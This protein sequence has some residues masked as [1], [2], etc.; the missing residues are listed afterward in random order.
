MSFG[1]FMFAWLSRNAR[2]GIAVRFLVLGAVVSFGYF[3]QFLL[4]EL[5]SMRIFTIFPPVR[6]TGWTVSIFAFLVFA[7]ILDLVGKFQIPELGNIPRTS[8]GCLRVKPLRLTHVVLGILTVLAF[9]WTISSHRAQFVWSSEFSEA[10]L[11]IQ[12]ES[13]DDEIFAISS[14]LPRHTFAVET[15]RPLFFGAGFPFIEAEMFEWEMPMKLSDGS[16]P[17]QP[18][19]ADGYFTYEPEGGLPTLQSSNLARFM[20]EENVAYFIDAW[21]SERLDTCSPSFADK[22]LRLFSRRDILNCS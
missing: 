22:S 15:N 13:A 5:L 8:T 17:K 21:D 10:T 7:L 9:S 11:W 12:T 20:E 4:V 3:G 16:L 18:P 19:F 2:D 14:A 1:I 6:L